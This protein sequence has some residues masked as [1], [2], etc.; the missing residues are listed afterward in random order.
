MQDQL[1]E[2]AFLMLFKDVNKIIQVNENLNR[3]TGNS[4]NIFN[5]L[6]DNKD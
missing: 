5:I 2:N 3:S 1:N 4:F 6:N